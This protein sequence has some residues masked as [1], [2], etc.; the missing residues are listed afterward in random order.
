MGAWW[1]KLIIHQY[2]VVIG[3]LLA[4]Y[5][6]VIYHCIPL[7][8]DL[9]ITSR[10]NIVAISLCHMI[11]WLLARYRKVQVQGWISQALHRL[12]TFFV[13]M[14][15]ISRIHYTCKWIEV[16]IYVRHRLVPKPYS[17]VMKLKLAINGYCTYSTS[18]ILAK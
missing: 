5:I 4:V 2:L 15:S 8:N 12:I 10:P 7:Y 6:A 17:C 1:D 14:Q 11:L 9:K 18:L 16:Q 13:I 3:I